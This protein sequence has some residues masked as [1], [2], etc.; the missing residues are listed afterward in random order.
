[1]DASDKSREPGWS[2]PTPTRFPFL[3]PGHVL[4]RWGSQASSSV[5]M[6]LVDSP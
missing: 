1:M 5:S 4:S 3:H 2:A 6:T